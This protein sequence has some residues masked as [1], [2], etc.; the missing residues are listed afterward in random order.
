MRNTRLS[1]MNL[2][3]SIRKSIHG[4]NSNAGLGGAAGIATSDADAASSI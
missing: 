3:G 2:V 1:L 4:N